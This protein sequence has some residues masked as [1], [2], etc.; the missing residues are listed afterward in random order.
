MRKVFQEGAVDGGEK[1]NE[2]VVEDGGN[3][4]ETVA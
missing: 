2:E 3:F 1:T 4:H